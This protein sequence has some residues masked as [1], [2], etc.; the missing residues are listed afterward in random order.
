[1]KELIN[2]GGQQF[3]YSTVEQV[4]DRCAKK[5]ACAIII[6]KIHLNELLTKGESIIGECVNQIIIISDDVNDA[7]TKLEGIGVLLIAAENFE[8]ATRLA[9]LGS[10]MSNAVICIPKEDEKTVGN[11]IEVIVT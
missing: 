10:A 4:I 9:I 11:I 1:V 8:E 2:I 3:Y 5:E 6:D 7:F